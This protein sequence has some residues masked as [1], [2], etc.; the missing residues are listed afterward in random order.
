MQKEKVDI[1]VSATLYK[2]LSQYAEDS[3]FENVEEFVNFVL[4]E[5]I[6]RGSGKE[7]GLTDDE[8]KEI[9]ENLKELGYK[10]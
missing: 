6:R 1:Q 3:G 10:S 5:V 9:D 2:S 4:D 7:K 8:K